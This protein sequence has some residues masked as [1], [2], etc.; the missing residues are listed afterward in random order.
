MSSKNSNQINVPEA[1]AAMDKF[2]MEAA[3][4]VEVPAPSKRFQ[5]T[6]TQI[7]LKTDEFT[8]DPGEGGRRAP[9]LPCPLPPGPASGERPW[10]EAAVPGTHFD[11]SGGKGG[12]FLLAI[13]G[14]L[15]YTYF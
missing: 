7:L 15:W 12:R 3:S 1:R 4:E 10:R 5:K 2:K 8:H 13:K 9:S 11:P 6:R 14:V